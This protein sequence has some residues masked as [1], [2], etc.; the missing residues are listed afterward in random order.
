MLEQQL[1]GLRTRARQQQVHTLALPQGLHGYQVLRHVIDDQQVDR[2]LRLRRVRWQQ[3]HANN[4]F[5]RR[6]INSRGSTASAPACCRAE[7]G[8]ID[9]SASSGH[10]SQA[11]PPA[12]RTAATPSL[13]SLL[14]PVSNSAST[15]APN[16]AASATTSA[17]VAVSSRLMPTESLSIARRL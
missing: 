16:T 8:I 15:C 12:A 13:P 6:H 2:G 17:R 1:Q 5:R 4:S 3:V 7:A 10:C 9:A 14:A 11:R